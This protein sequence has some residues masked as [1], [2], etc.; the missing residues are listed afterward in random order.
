MT[1]FAAKAPTHPERTDELHAPSSLP[2]AP[3]VSRLQLARRFAIVILGV[4]LAVAFSA[5]G[6]QLREGWESHRDWVVPA[7]VSGALISGPALAYLLLTGRAKIA[8]IGSLLMFVALAFMLMHLLYNMDG[9][10]VSGALNDFFSITGAVFYV[11]G[12]IALQLGLVW[13]IMVPK[14][15]AP[16]EEA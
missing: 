1:N 15:E 8:A 11:G 5:I 16:A 13:A 12:L 4:I 9:D 10:D 2:D 14:K 6:I 3:A 7:A